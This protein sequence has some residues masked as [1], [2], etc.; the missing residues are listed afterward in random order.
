MT[1]CDRTRHWRLVWA[2]SD[3]L[4]LCSLFTSKTTTRALLSPWAV[5]S[6]LHSLILADRHPSALDLALV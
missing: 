6:H 1:E 3:L 4:G 5:Y 2:V